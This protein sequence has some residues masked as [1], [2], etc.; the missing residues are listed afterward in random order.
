MRARAW[1]DVL[2]VVVLVAATLLLLQVD[3]SW[4]YH[5]VRG[6]TTLK[7]YVIFNVLEARAPLGVHRSLPKR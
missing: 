5:A 3:G 7:L 1:D 6:Q 2:R 4:L